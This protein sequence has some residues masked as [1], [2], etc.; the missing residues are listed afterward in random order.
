MK[1]VK[2]TFTQTFVLILTLCTFQSCMLF[3][4]ILTEEDVVNST[5]RVRTDFEYRYARERYSPLVSITQT[6]VKETKGDSVG[7]ITFYERIRLNSNSFKLENKVYLLIDNVP[8]PGKVE[9]VEYERV[10]NMEEKRK[11]VMTVDSTKISVVTGFD[12]HEN[13]IY[14]LTYSIDE[15]LIEKIKE[16]TKIQFRYYA[17]PDMITTAMNSFELKTLKL[18]ISTH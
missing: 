4:N 9:S 18:L 3:R 10:S 17:G 13:N 8:Y 6:I 7:P 15:K 14:K 5:K 1:R 11:D 12:N 2:H 16:A